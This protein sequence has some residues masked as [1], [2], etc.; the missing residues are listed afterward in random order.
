M[1]IKETIVKN[2]MEQPKPVPFRDLC[3]LC[4]ENEGFTNI[5]SKEGLS[6]DI[7]LCTGVVISTQDSLPQ[8][9]CFKCIEIV[10]N[11]KWLR[12][13]SMSTERHLKS[14]FLDDEPLILEFSQSEKLKDPTEMKSNSRRSSTDS[15]RTIKLEI[16]ET[17]ISV[18]KEEEEDI[19]PKKRKARGSDTS[20]ALKSSKP[21][22]KISVRKDLFNSPQAP[23][24]TSSTKDVVTSIK[25]N[26]KVKIKRI[27]TSTGDSFYYVCD[28]CQK[29]FNAWKKYYL[30]QK[31][32]NRNIVC[33][34]CEKK[35]AT[36][37]DVEKHV[38]TH[39]G[40]RPFACDV[41]DRRFSQRGSLKSHKI[42]VHQQDL[43]TLTPEKQ[44]SNN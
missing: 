29:K 14:L 3:R 2:I 28:L 23:S 21:D 1:E 12:D 9:I 4:L 36:K 10:V 37:G 24:V 44:E 39:T 5:C 35:F 30:H 32:H 25:Q 15:D 34:V 38:R 42:S 31:T 26:L 16:D 18:T 17:Q 19:R 6:H 43:N 11:A 27:K 8:K 20:E 7:Y 33:P 13:K 22:K 40:E 41:C